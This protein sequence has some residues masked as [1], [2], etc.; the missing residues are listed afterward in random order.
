MSARMR[1][2]M[3]RGDLEALLQAVDLGTRVMMEGDRV[4]GQ[5]QFARFAN[6]A[7][8][9]RWLGRVTLATTVLRQMLEE[10]R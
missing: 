5:W 4:D 8:A 6:D 1:P 7:E 2:R 3:S 10:G 9:G